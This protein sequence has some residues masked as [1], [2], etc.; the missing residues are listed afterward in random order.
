MMNSVLSFF[1]D[2]SIVA[3]SVRTYIQKIILLPLFFVGILVLYNNFSYFYLTVC[4]VFVFLFN[5]V[6]M[7][8]GTHRYL[9]HRS[10]KVNSFFNFFLVLFSCLS[11]VGTLRSQVGMHRLHH[12]YEDTIY[13]PQSQ[14][15]VGWWHLY[16][17]NFP[18]INTS[19]EFVSLT[20]DI[21]NSKLIAFVDNNYFKIILFYI[22]ILLWIDP[23]LFWFAYV[24]P[25]GFVLNTL[26]IGN[27]VSHKFGYTNFESNNKSKNSILGFI[28]SLGS[29]GWHN[30]HHKY[31]YR[32]NHGFKWWEIDPTSWF[33]RIIKV[34]NG[35]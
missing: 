13:D 20:K 21:G 2:N 16:T 8:A 17:N 33:I 3:S 10:F 15:Y 9:S 6:G 19:R 34:Q 12:K 31:P 23:L 18:F 32:W 5:N 25:A 4:L 1:F 29:N 35:N 26:G 30:N 14:E 22:F 28:M 11:S 27:I 7:D 24:I